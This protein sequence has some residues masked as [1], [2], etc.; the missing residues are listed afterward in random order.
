MKAE[1]SLIKDDTEE[2]SDSILL[3]VQEKKNFEVFCLYG[4]VLFSPVLLKKGA[5]SPH[6][7]L[8]HMGEKL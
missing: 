3:Y 1:T 6:A 4:K 7:V 8:L 2:H 5:N